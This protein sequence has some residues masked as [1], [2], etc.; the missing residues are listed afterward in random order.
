MT[1]KM[2]CNLVAMKMGAK[3]GNCSF[4][5][6]SVDFQVIQVFIRND[7]SHSDTAELMSY[8][9]AFPPFLCI[10]HFS[11]DSRQIKLKKSMCEHGPHSPTLP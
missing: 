9:G 4:T 5:V 2:Q 6:N 10:S 3:V 8:L 7:K 11:H 1:M